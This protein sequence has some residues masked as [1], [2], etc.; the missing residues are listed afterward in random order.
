V[1]VRPFPDG[2]REWRISIRGGRQPRW[3][4]DGNEIFYVE[5]D[6]LMAVPVVLQPEFDHGDPVKLFDGEGVFQGRGQQYD[7][8]ADGKRFVVVERTDTGERQIQVVLNWYE[9][10]RT[11]D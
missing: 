4:G 8:T 10:F 5:D 2:G 7:V 9:E 1:Y 6:T 11:R 3:Q